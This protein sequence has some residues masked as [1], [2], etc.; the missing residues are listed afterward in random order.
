MPRRRALRA[1][2]ALLGVWITL[3]LLYILHLGP[4][5]PPSDGH[6]R[7]D[8][9]QG[10][11]VVPAPASV[12]PVDVASDGGD[13]LGQDEES[14]P[15]EEDAPPPDTPMPPPLQG[16]GNDHKEEGS[17]GEAED[18]EAA[19]KKL[20]HRVEYWVK[21]SNFGKARALYAEFK[22]TYAD[23]A[24]SAQHSLRSAVKLLK[25][26]G[27]SVPPKG[28]FG[29]VEWLKWAG[30]ATCPDE[31]AWDGEGVVL[32]YFWELWCP[33]CR[34]AMPNIQA[35]FDRF[36]AHGLVVA[37]LTRMSKGTREKSIKAHLTKHHIRFPNGK[38]QGD[39]SKHFG[40]SGIPA[41]AV[42]RKGKVVWR[43]HPGNL[44]D[45]MLEG[46]LGQ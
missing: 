42:V 45:K 19:A 37:G 28:G 14:A 8:P 1:W 13:K 12:D 23:T 11:A 39:F 17:G 32:L 25:V 24:A 15:P 43:G 20:A 30:A 5:P 36:A 35:M 18:P 21:A 46:W 6:G 31:D 34:K 4:D 40:V 7:P 9:V 22:R 44:K 26:V 10:I 38:E 27:K 41:A 16:V 3:Q 2:L 33:H 29:A